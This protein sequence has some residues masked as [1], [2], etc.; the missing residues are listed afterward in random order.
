MRTGIVKAVGVATGQTL[1]QGDTLV[2]IGDA[3]SADADTFEA[4]E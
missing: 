3:T 4:D 1:N 2:T